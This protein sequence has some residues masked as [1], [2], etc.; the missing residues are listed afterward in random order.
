MLKIEIIGKEGG[1]L[2]VKPGTNSPF[3]ISAQEI[4][5]PAEKKGTFSK[6]VTLAETKNNG[7][8]LGFLFGIDVINGGFDV[9]KRV[10]V[11]LFNGQTEIE[12]NFFLIRS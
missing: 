11:R 7:E 2:D 10:N 8:K 1:F 5:K 3:T 9:N 12:G 6:T 4:R